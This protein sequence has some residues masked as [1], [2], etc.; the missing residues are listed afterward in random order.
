MRG[1]KGQKRKKRDGGWGQKSR[2]REIQGER[3]QSRECSSA[4]SRNMS[5]M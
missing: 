2:W 3:E 4:S 1:E 5:V